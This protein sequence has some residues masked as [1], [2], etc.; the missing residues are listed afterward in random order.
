MVQSLTF[1][2]A[3]TQTLPHTVSNQQPISGFRDFPLSIKEII[4]LCHLSTDVIWLVP[5]ME[6]VFSLP[7]TSHGNRMKPA[8][9]TR[10]G[11]FVATLITRPHTGAPCEWR[12]ADCLSA[13]TFNLNPHRD[14]WVSI[15]LA[16]FSGNMI[17]E[18]WALP[19]LCSSFHFSLK[20][21]TQAHLILASEET[22]KFISMLPKRNRGCIVFMKGSALNTQQPLLPLQH[23]MASE[24]PRCHVSYASPPPRKFQFTFSK[25]LC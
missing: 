7:F 19:S 10:V 17:G 13:A 4:K 18:L 6:W 1:I 23:H 14:V 21:K 24:G 25:S 8:N 11:D 22:I 9:E 3:Y 2:C 16:S 15:R 20:L 5:G 12:V